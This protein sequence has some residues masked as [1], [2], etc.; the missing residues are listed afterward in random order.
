MNSSLLKFHIISKGKKC[1]N[2]PKIPDVASNFGI[3]CINLFDMMRA[4][5]FDFKKDYSKR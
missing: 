1:S 2:N 5:N 3:N 4:L